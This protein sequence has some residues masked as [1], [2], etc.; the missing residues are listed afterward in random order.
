MKSL[1]IIGVIVS[2]IF[3]FPLAA[4]TFVLPIEALFQEETTAALGVALNTPGSSEIPL[5]QG[6]ATFNWQSIESYF[7]DKLNEVS[8]DNKISHDGP[9][10]FWKG[11]E[12][13]YIIYQSLLGNHSLEELQKDIHE[14]IEKSAIS[15]KNGT[16]AMSQIALDK[17]AQAAITTINRET[18]QLAQ[19]LE[20][21]G[22]TVIFTGNYNRE[23]LDAVKEKNPELNKFTMLISADL[24]RVKSPDF[25]KELK[26]K[27]NLNP[28]NTIFV[29]SHQMYRDHLKSSLPDAKVEVCTNLNKAAPCIERFA[30]LVANLKNAH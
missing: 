3:I 16:K 12:V 17:Q 29:E 11:L 2:L 15:F 20:S 7:F 26:A 27:L 18:L 14:Q 30:Q 10:A 9:K 25:Y 5:M 23:V 4:Q 19:K 13:P 21:S 6:A 8:K 24:K 28:H 1:N 22:H